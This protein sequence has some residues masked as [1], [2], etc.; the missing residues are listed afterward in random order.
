MLTWLL[1]EPGE[2][3][4]VQ[5]DGPEKREL[6]WGEQC[7]GSGAQRSWGLCV[8]PQ[9]KPS[10]LSMYCRASTVEGGVKPPL[11]LFLEQ[12]TE[13]GFVLQDPAA[14]LAV[15]P[16]AVLNE[17]RLET[18]FLEGQVLCSW[19]SL[20]LPP[21]MGPVVNLPWHK[22]AGCRTEQARPLSSHFSAVHGP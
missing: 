20:H 19:V 8:S 15:T 7:S 2:G 12:W 22:A 17:T 1:V 4:Q 11:C 14:E 21:L 6:P 3:S 13:Q 16:S 9:A 18:F 5:W 10:A